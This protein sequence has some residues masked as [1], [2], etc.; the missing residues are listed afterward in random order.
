MFTLT[1]AAR[2]HASKPSPP[3]SGCDS[4]RRDE[5]PTSPPRRRA[6]PSALSARPSSWRSSV[7]WPWSP[8]DVESSWP[9]TRAPRPCGSRRGTCRRGRLC[10]TRRS[11]ATGA[12]GRAAGACVDFSEESRRW[13]GDEAIIHAGGRV[14]R[15][16]AIR[17]SQPSAYLSW[18]A[19]KMPK[20]LPTTSDARRRE[21]LC[22]AAVTFGRQR[23]AASASTKRSHGGASGAVFSRGAE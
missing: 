14:S 15:A 18:R 8:R 12:A 17:S 2:Q 4:S 19:A 20:R 11:R 6:S 9:R 13:R 1:T 10:A 22:S 5:G 3:G 16:R 7:P 21:K 23:N